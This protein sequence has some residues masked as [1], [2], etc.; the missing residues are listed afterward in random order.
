M[1]LFLRDAVYNYDLCQ[2][3]DLWHLLSRLEVPL[4]KDVATA[5]CSEPEGLS[6]PRWPGIKRLSPVTSA[7]YQRVAGEVARRKRIHR[8]DLDVYYWR[9]RP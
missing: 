6:L 8:V 5:L 1:N 9:P 2:Q 4:D 3:F 7:A